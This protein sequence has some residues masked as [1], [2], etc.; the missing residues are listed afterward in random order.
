MSSSEN[1]KEI[2]VGDK[3]FKSQKKS[4]KHKK[5]SLGA[6]RSPHDRRDWIFEKLR[7]ASTGGK[8]VVKNTLPEKVD[9]RKDIPIVYD[10]GQNPICAAATVAGAKAWQ[11]KGLNTTFSPQFVYNHR[12]NYPND[13]MHGRDVMEILKNNG[14]CREGF[15]RV[16]SSH[17]KHDRTKIPKEAIKDGL[18]FKIKSYAK[19][20]TPEGL[21]TVLYKY[22]PCYISF[23]VYDTWSSEFWRNNGKA[24]IG[25][26]AVAVVGYNDAKGHFILRNSW[27]L[28]W[29][30]FGHTYYKYGDFGAHW[31]IW[32]MVD[33]VTPPNID[34]EPKCKCVIL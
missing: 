30:D 22:G 21:K 8:M 12:R 10:Q 11:E 20:T 24:I 14:C 23:P 31:E 26:H 33:D 2:I 6:I 32:S 27:G 9:L 17:M 29:G 3:D 16:S 1:E 28:M 7:L 34:P 13:G 19:V 4:K 15:Y 5:L 25:G 18:N